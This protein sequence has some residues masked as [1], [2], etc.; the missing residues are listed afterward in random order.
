MANHKSS[1]SAVCSFR[2]QR[3]LHPNFITTG[4]NRIQRR[5]CKN[6][7]VRNTSFVKL[8]SNR[9]L[10]IGRRRPNGNPIQFQEALF[11]ERGPRKGDTPLL[12]SEAFFKK[13]TLSYDFFNSL[14]SLTILFE[15]A[16]KKTPIR[17]KSYQQ[18]L[19]PRG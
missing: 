11:Q 3:T 17:V 18:D 4:S 15:Q 12:A 2:L 1:Q 16:K 9:F 6:K 14:S 7:L 5:N 19:S 13:N 10:E 8:S